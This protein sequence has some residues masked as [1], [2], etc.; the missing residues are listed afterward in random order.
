MLFRSPG[1]YE[2]YLWRKSQPGGA[3]EPGEF[4]ASAPL[5]TTPD[6]ESSVEVK[7]LNPLKLKKM[8]DRQGEIEEEVARLEAEIAAYEA[9]LADF[10]SAEETMR[11]ME[12]LG[13]LRAEL[14]ERLAEWEQV[15]SS[16]EANS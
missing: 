8:Q 16:I 7:R 11:L 3:R 1:N 9:E 2:D 15:S 4:D 12:L 13:A 14:E 6:G 10:K 5:Q